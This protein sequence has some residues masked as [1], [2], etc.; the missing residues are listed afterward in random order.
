M[1]D[2][3]GGTKEFDFGND[4]EAGLLVAAGG[5]EGRAITFIKKLRKSSCTFEHSLLIEYES[6]PGDN[7]ENYKWLRERLKKLIGKNP[8]KVSV[9]SDR[10]VQ[11]CGDIKSE[12]ET[13]A[14][15]V[16]DKTAWIDISGMTHLWA[17]AT[18]H[19]CLSSG[20]RT[21]VVFTEA[22]RYFPLKQDK[23]KLV[24]AWRK[25]DY[26]KC[27]E[28]LQSA[29]L[30]SIHILPEFGGNFRPGRQTCLM[31]FVGYEPNRTEGL[32]N[33]YAPGRLIVLYGRSPHKGL[34]WRTK[35]SKDLHEELFSRWYV[36]ETEISTLRVDETLAKLE[37]EFQVIREQFDVAIS[38]LC[39]KMQALAI[40]LFWRRHPE[41]QLIFTSPVRFNPERYSKGSHK[42]YIYEIP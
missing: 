41:V 23:K 5:F 39:S 16:V 29:A 35:L 30:K 20:F 32:V 3:N 14:S 38:P 27:K 11:S 17:L 34:Q 2:I 8:R 21:F 22:K 18:I 24:Q 6:Q 7:E 13:I 10:P 26:P 33:D 40:Y 36:R 19:A 12:I 31:V 1:V 42:T 37:E 4:I 9:H 28:Y 25:R 15:K